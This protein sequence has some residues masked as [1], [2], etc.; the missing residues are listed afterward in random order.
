METKRQQQLL[1]IISIFI[2]LQ[3]FFDILSFLDIRGILPISISTY[4]KPLIVL[5]LS[6]YFFIKVKNNRKFWLLYAFMF[7]ILIVGHF[8][9]LYLIT[10]KKEIILHELRFVINIVYMILKN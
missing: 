4:L 6:L 3:P 10:T 5:V 7:L 8:T 9:N 1:N 2:L